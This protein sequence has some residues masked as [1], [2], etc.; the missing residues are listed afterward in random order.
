MSNTNDLVERIQ[1]YDGVEKFLIL[2]K[3]GNKLN[4]EI[5]DEDKGKN[6]PNNFNS[7]Y[8]DIPKLVDKAISVARDVNPLVKIKMKYF[9]NIF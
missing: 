3:N 7:N 4:S 2:N 9:L 1:R 8:S 6:V 5:K